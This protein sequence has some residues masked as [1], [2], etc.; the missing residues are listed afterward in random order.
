M[1]TLE[2][3]TNAV[4]AS[5]QVPR[6]SSLS[7]AKHVTFPNHIQVPEALKNV[8]TFG[9]IDATF[10]PRVD[11][12]NGTGGDNFSIGAVESSQDTD[13]TTKEPSPR[14]VNAVFCVY[15]LGLV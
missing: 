5:S 1:V 4:E 11:S 6:D 8:L 10:G 14:L 3:A 15:L 2:V 12:V 13:E 7:V 9:S